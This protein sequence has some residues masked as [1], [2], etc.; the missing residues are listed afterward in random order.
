MHESAMTLKE[1]GEKLSFPEEYQIINLERMIK[2]E[3]NHYA[4][5]SITDSD[6]DHQ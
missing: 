6:K 5:S 1:K 4:I 3:N 2:S